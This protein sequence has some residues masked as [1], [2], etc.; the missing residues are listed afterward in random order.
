MR[1]A[2]M[3][4]IV[5]LA[6]L[7]L[8]ANLGGAKAD[9]DC[10]APLADWQPREALVSKLESEG[11][12]N[13]AIRIEDGCYL[14]HAVNA[15][16]ERLHGMFDPAT[17]TPVSGGHRDRDEEGHRRDRMQDRERER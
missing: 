7:V 2:T 9:W 4:L 6:S 17:L 11:W 10:S 16:G 5:L 3:G 15:S 8:F 1:V 14:A 12:R 13:I